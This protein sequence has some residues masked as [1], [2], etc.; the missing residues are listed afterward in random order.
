M[1][2]TPGDFSDDYLCRIIA[3]TAEDDNVDAK[4]PM[5][6]SDAVEK[7]GLAKDIAAFANSNNG[8][9]LV[10]GKRQTEPGQFILEGLNDE[11]AAS[12]ETTVVAQWVNNH[13][14]PEIRLECRRV[15]HDG[16]T[17]I[18][19]RINEFDDVPIICTKRC[20]DPA[21]SRK[22]IL[23]VGYIYIRGRNAESKPLQTQ[24][25]FRRLIGTAT[26]K[27]RDDIIQHLDA[28][29]KGQ[30]PVD[31]TTDQDR[32]SRELEAIRS[33]LRSQNY[34]SDDSGWEIL[35]HPTVYQKERWDEIG[36]VEQVVLAHSLNMPDRFPDQRTGTFPTPWGIANSTYW[37]TW[38]FSKSGVFYFNKPFEEDD[39]HTIARILEYITKNLRQT[40]EYRVQEFREQLDT[41]RWVD[42]DKNM[43]TIMK[44]FAFMRHLVEAFDEGETL[45]YRYCV[46]DLKN[47]YSFSFNPRR[48]M[49]LV[50]EYRDPCQVSSPLVIERVATVEDV[51]ANWQTYCVEVMYRF[52]ELFPG[53]PVSKDGLMGWVRQY[54]GEGRK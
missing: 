41:H 46:R 8:G 31:R 40:N 6:F 20:D 32:F 39:T 49:S 13:F 16:R 45:Y 30:P 2:M 18:V 12:F 29:L 50:P 42:L 17:F 43:D 21:N 10:I 23:A 48:N 34:Y 51:I 4:G 22:P 53:I 36:K 15:E 28:M 14:A 33:D 26:K 7:A 52:L 9:W 35:F 37:E 47:R 5:A 3:N 27:R 24:E 1:E 38:A 44:T 19:I 11:Q 54:T 25:E